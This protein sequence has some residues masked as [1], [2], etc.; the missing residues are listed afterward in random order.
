MTRCRIQVPYDA[1]GC[2]FVVVLLEDCDLVIIGVAAAK[3]AEHLQLAPN[4]LGLAIGAGQVGL[5][6]GPAALD[7]QADQFARK[8]MSGSSALLCGVFTVATSLASIAE[9][10]AAYPSSPGSV[11]GERYQ[12]R[13]PFG[14]EYS[15]NRLHASL[16]TMMVSTNGQSITYESL[17]S[18]GHLQA[19]QTMSEVHGCR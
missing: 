1:Q 2:R 15:S 4:S 18:R 14:C 16:A 13:W 3:I 9:Q 19:Y 6:I 12:M 5:L 8:R 10:L 11:V 7:I 17:L